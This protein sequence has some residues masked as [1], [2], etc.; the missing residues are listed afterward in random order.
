MKQAQIPSRWSWLVPGVLLGAVYG[1]L[2]YGESLAD[3]RDS[4]E[5]EENADVV[6]GLY[7]KQYYKPGTGNQ[8]GST[9]NENGVVI[10]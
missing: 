4:G 10:R 2:Q 5:H 1:L 9:G 8:P 3:L 6:I 7:S